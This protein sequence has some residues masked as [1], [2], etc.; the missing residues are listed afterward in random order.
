MD[1]TETNYQ[2]APEEDASRLRRF[3]QCFGFCAAATAMLL[4][5]G[6]AKS[7]QVESRFPKPLMQPYQIVVG[8]RYPASLTEF[9][10]T[11]ES[12]NE[13]DI[14]IN[15]STANV[16]MFR[17]LFSGM[18]AESV[19]LGSDPNAPVPASIDL[20]IEPTL[21]DLEIAS[22]GKSGTDQYTVWLNYN[23]RLSRPDGTLLDDWKVTAYGQRDQGSMGMGGEDAVNDATVI[24]LRDAAANIVT[25]FSTVPG[26]SSILPAATAPDSSAATHAAAVAES[27]ADDDDTGNGASED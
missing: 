2:S 5:A 23:L 19:E 1:L 24:A 20:I 16:D 25:E 14:V 3:V 22:P 26:I 21:T 11:E 15:L 6:C 9:S 27:A 7:V 12:E 4:L 8:V 10:H 18:F 13:P 17:A